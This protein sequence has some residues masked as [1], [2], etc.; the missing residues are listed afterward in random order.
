[1]PLYEY[2]CQECGV[3]F[4]KIVSF[5]E[6]DKLPSCP[7]CGAKDTRKLIS[8][9]AFLGATSR[10]GGSAITAPPPNRFT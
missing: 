1:M 2:T 8:A 5:A 7:T 10:S 3:S 9:G 4:D 6:A